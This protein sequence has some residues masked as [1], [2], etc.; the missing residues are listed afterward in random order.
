MKKEYEE[1]LYEIKFMEFINKFFK[2]CHSPT[3]VYD[4][5]EVLCDTLGVPYLVMHSATQRCILGEHKIRVLP[6]EK[7]ILY[8]LMGNGIRPTARKLNINTG[9]IYYHM[10]KYESGDMDV[11]PK[12]PPHERREIM[13]MMKQL[14]A[15]LHIID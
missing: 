14:S 7:I 15:L 8:V 10:K 5:I 4:F 3:R 6:E 1:R 9:T 2:N 13:S 12:F 11:S